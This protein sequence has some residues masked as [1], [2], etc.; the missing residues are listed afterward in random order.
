[1]PKCLLPLLTG[2]AFA[3]FGASAT[4]ARPPTVDPTYG[5]PAPRLQAPARPATPAQWIWVGQTQ[6]TQTVSA[7]G[8]ITL[9]ASP[10]SATLF[11]TG[12]D[13]ATASVNGR[14]IITTD[15]KEQGWKQ[16]RRE[17][18]AAL[19]HAGRN[20]IAVQ[21]VNGGGAAG[22]LAQLEV[23][24]KT[25]LQTGPLWKVLETATPPTGWTQADFNDSAWPDATALAPV[26]QGPWG[27]GLVNWP[28]QDTAWYLAHLTVP[29]VALEPLSGQASGTPSA[30]GLAI[31]AVPADGTPA[32]VRVDFGKEI[33]GRLLLQGTPGTAIRVTTGETVAELT[34]AEPA[35]DN[36]GPYTL[37][38]V[39][40]EPATTPYS[41]FRY[42]LLTFPSRQAAKLTRIECDHKYYPVAYKGSFACSDPLLTR[43]WYAG[44]YT[45]HLCMQEDIWDAPKRDRGLWCGDLHV[46]GATIND[47]FADKFLM[48]RSIA[49]LAKTAPG[50]GVRSHPAGRGRQ[51]APRLHGSLVLRTGR[52]LPPRRGRGV[53]CGA[54][55]RRS[56]PCWPTNK[57]SLTP[58]IC[59]STRTTNWNFVDWAP[60]F[61]LDSPQSHEATDLFDVQGVHEAVYLL[62]AMGDTANA[63]KY[64]A[65]AKTLTDAA[66]EDYLDPATATYGDRLQPNVMAVYSGV[67]TPAQ[68]DAIY[69]HIL[70]AGSP[71]W[72]PPAAGERH[73]GLSD[74][75]LLREL[76]AAG[77]RRPGQRQDGIDLIR[78]YW[79]AM[80]ARGTTT[81]WEQFDPAMPADFNRVL[82]MTPYLSFSHGWS[83]G[84]TSFLSEYVLGV[85]PTS[86]GMQTVEIVPFLGDLAWAEGAMPAPRD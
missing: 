48:E 28:G 39:A 40:S 67:A 51:L 24:G 62:R 43:I 42:A 9:P 70:Q 79:G 41:A 25:V 33:A 26:G 85:R 75:A 11:V 8:T 52:L 37:T 14:Q 3:V 20:V 22:I 68:R 47:V 66:R 45:A 46:T 44:A 2:L 1:M 57:A 36:S 82:D 50:G 15:P 55:T 81:L 61:V 71:A 53:S 17:P 13:V 54:S 59:S 65:W 18:V 6:G 49:G 23:N 29:P 56:S 58:I 12:D 64:D 38:L 72:K 5:L 80:M 32:S 31:K 7:R 10:H 30:G 34:H 16:V 35:L 69:A 19:L 77:L 76:R 74:D 63:D 21:G 73:G 86:G 83:T 4:S 84:P 78:R 60:D 27:T